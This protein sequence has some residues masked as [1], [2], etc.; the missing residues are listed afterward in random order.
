[1]TTQDTEAALP[2]DPLEELR[3]QLDA[4]RETLRGIRAD[5]PDALVI[6]SGS[7]EELFSGAARAMEELRLEL[8]EAREA[9]HAIRTGGFDAL[10]IDA[11]RGEEVFALGGAGRPDRLLVG[12]IAR[13]GPAT[14][15]RWPST[16]T[17]P[18][19][20]A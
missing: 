4:A 1:M 18:W 17:A 6:G 12:G 2:R 15:G 13:A 20:T 16:T 14:S 7:G 9:L 8:D 10:V 19:L 3:R 11:G 5:G